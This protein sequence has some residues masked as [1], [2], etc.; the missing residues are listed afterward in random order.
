MLSLQDSRGY[1]F[2]MLAGAASDAR[3]YRFKTLSVIALRCLLVPLL[4]AG[5]QYRLS[6]S[7]KSE[8]AR[9]KQSKH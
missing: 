8:I 6:Y 9:S 4:D 5:C 7:M 2:E 3:C 1:R